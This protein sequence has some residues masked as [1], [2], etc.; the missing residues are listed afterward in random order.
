MSWYQLLEIAEVNRQKR[1]EE[2][3]RPPLACPNDGT[4]LVPAPGSAESSLYC[5][6]DGWQYPRDDH[7][8]AS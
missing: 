8:P 4:P 7:R 3:S 5:P 2:L 6:F 1:R